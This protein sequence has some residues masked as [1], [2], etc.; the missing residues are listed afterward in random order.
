MALGIRKFI[1]NAISELNVLKFSFRK[2]IF[3]FEYAN[4]M[5]RSI[6]K[7]SLTKILTAY[8]A[9]LGKGCDIETGLTFHNCTDYVNFSVGDNAHVG[10]NCF[11]DLAGKI[12]IGKNA[13]VSMNS[14]F[15]THINIHR[16]ELEKIYP[17][18][19]IEI[20]IGDDTYIG[21][22]SI[23]LMG[24]KLGKSCMVAAGSTVN[25]SFGPGSFIAGSPAEF[26]KMLKSDA[27]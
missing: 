18:K 13:V 26:K 25:K 17:P 15:L 5:I 19:V 2:T 27:E 9:N 8:G 7:K 4:L 21:A 20:S 10:K 1:Q 12:N 14:I 16:S 23:V 24:V 3:G 22:G 6:D 11:F